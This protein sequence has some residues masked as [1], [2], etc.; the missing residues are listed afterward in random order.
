[1]DPAKPAPLRGCGRLDPRTVVGGSDAG[2]HLDMMCGA[3]YSTAL[4]ASVRDHNTVTWE[5]AIEQLTSVPADLYGLVDRGRLAAGCRADLTLFDPG[6][7]G[8]DVERTL[9]DLPGGGSRIFTGAI[10]VPHVL[11]N[12]VQVVTDG[13]LT[14]STPGTVLR[15]GRD[16]RTVP[17][18][19]P[20]N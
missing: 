13:K 6:T 7:V 18:P 17:V 3:A 12:G 11:V 2:A 8:P 4:L 14:G 20:L 5:E 15:S 9:D 10:G 1:M 19:G 16:T